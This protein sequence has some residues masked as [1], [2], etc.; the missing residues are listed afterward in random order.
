MRN[1][2]FLPLWY[3]FQLPTVMLMS[4]WW[5][6]HP[7]HNNT[8]GANAFISANLLKTTFLD[9]CKNCNK[10]FL[11]HFPYLIM[12]HVL[13]RK[14]FLFRESWKIHPNRNKLLL[15]FFQVVFVLFLIWVIMKRKKYKCKLNKIHRLFSFISLSP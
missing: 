2:N 9:W 14:K 12:I 6:K 1:N 11:L 4:F 5:W 3:F 15:R 7:S 8:F 13:Y 10:S